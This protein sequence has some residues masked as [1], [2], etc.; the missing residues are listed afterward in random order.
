MYVCHKHCFFFVSQYNRAISWPLVLH[1][2]NYKTLFLDFGFVA[3][4]TKFGL[5]L[6]K[7]QLATS[8]LF[9]DRIEPFFGRQFSM[10]PST[11]RCS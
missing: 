11:K 7:V 8:F 10:T 6:Q 3:M 4:A 1:D 9:I 2:K 5:F